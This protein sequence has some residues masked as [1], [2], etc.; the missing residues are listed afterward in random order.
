MRA[1]SVVVVAVLAAVASA[2]APEPGPTEEPSPAPTDAGTATPVAANV[3]VVLGG[4][5][6]LSVQREAGML[7]TETGGADSPASRRLLSAG[8]APPLDVDGRRLSVAFALRPG[9]WTGPGR[10]ELTDEPDEGAPASSAD[11]VSV[12]LMR[13]EPAELVVFTRLA[14]PCSVELGEHGFTGRLECP[15]LEG[16]R[17][18]A[19]SLVFTWE[20]R[21]APTPTPD[22]IIT[23]QPR[24]TAGP[25]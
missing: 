1:R 4:A 16:E 3:S 20:G 9:T 7:V 18:A 12:E 23:P 19:V 6:Q 21:A 8:V 13:T 15:Q 5:V 22:R 2:C 25:P 11:V 14:R 24:T 17:G 10:Y